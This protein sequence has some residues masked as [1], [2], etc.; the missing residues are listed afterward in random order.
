MV[1]IA[2]KLMTEIPKHL[3]QRAAQRRAVLEAQ[4]TQEPVVVT[5]AVPVYLRA[6]SGHVIKV[7]HSHKCRPPSESETQDLWGPGTLWEC[8]CGKR[9][10]LSSNHTWTD[11]IF[12]GGS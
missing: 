5:N 4:K 8:E 2:R 9:M 3:L 1:M 6:G 10:E 12:A 11:T 7:V